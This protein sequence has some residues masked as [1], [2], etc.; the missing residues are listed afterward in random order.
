VIATGKPPSV[1]IREGWTWTEVFTA[2]GC[3]QIVSSLEA[4]AMK[5]DSK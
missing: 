1:L 3:K 2:A 5:G 4:E